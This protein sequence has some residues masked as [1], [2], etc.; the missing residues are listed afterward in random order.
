M[1]STRRRHEIRSAYMEWAKTRSNARFNL[2]TSGLANFTIAKLPARLEDL[3]LTGLGGYGYEPLQRRLAAKSQVAPE[4]VVAAA[5][6]SM[7]NHLAMSALLDPGDEVLIEH[8]TYGLLLDVAEYLGARIRRFPRPFENDFR[9]EPAEVERAVTSQTRLIVIT[10]LHNPSGVLTAES[11]LKEIADIARK[12]GAHVLVDEVYLDAAFEL[13]PR[14]SFRLA[15]NFVVTT[16]LTKVYGLSGLRCGWI[17]AVP[18]LAERMWRLNDLFGASAAHPAERL[19]VVALDHL[20]EIAAHSRTVLETNRTLLKRFLDSRTGIR[21]VWPE[22]GT[23]VFPRLSNTN[24]N[25]F[26]ARL[27]DTYDTSVVPGEFFEMPSH[28]RIGVGGDTEM[29]TQGLTQLAR[30]LDAN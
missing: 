13:A 19:S 25:S 23:I 10:N 17:L 15:D 2:A 1:T 12:V 27:R 7:A 5:G 14:T 29:V 16:S 4:C 6:T 9:I 18:E 21:A 26:F 11:V 3:E 8:P 22:A 20:D 30:A 24:P 28:F